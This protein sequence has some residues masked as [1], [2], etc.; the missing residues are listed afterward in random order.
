MWWG[1]GGEERMCRGVM[2]IDASYT[3]IV[4]GIYTHVLRDVKEVGRKCY[5]LPW[6]GVVMSDAWMCGGVM[7]EM[8]EYVEG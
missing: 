3:Y 1:D 7:E 2:E 5:L 4:E 6:V 8:S